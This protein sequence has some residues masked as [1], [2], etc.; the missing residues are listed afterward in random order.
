IGCLVYCARPDVGEISIL[1]GSPPVV[2]PAE[3]KVQAQS[4]IDFEIV[5]NECIQIGDPPIVVISRRDRSPDTT[6]NAA[7][8]RTI[9]VA[10]VSWTARSC[11]CEGGTAGP[12]DKEI[13]PSRECRIAYGITVVICRI[14]HPHKLEAGANGVLAVGP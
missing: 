9:R 13:G 11:S 2:F 1:F 8:R 12:A 14:L 6:R 3:S 4:G 7:P 5:L 10:G